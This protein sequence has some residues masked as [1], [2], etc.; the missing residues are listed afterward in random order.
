MF[1]TIPSLI[2]KS[3]PGATGGGFTPADISD[4]VGWWDAE[5]G[6]TLSGT[7]VTSW[8]DQS[9]TAGDFTKSTGTN[10]TY[11]SSGFGVNSKPYIRTESATYYQTSSDWPSTSASTVY[12]IC[13]FFTGSNVVQYGRWWASALDYGAGFLQLSTDGT[14]GQNASFSSDL[15]TR[16]TPSYDTPSVIRTKWN[17]VSSNVRLN[18]GSEVASTGV[19]ASQSSGKVIIGYTNLGYVNDFDVAEIIIYNKVLDAGELTQVDNYLSTK[20]GITL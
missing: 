7:D 1:S 12:I 20:Y 8:V 14:L 4:L 18:N 9:N 16:I 3:F 17:G 6:V 19:L 10:Y 15:S 13:N 5:Q 11:N 2:E